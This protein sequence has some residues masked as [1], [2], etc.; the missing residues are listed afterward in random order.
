LLGPYAPWD[1]NPILSAMGLPDNRPDPV[2][3]TGH[4]DLVQTQ[5]GEWFAVFLGCQPYEQG[6][7][8]TGR[9]TFMHPVK[10]EDGWPVILPPRTPVPLTVKKPNLPAGETVA[11]P[12]TG[13]ISFTDNFDADKLAFRWVGLRAPVSQWYALS[14]ASKAL[15][16][17]PRAD[18]LS[19][20]G[21]PSFLAVRQQNNDFTCSVT[22]KAQAGTAKCV[23]GL[24]AYQNEGHFYALNAKIES[25]RITE[26][27]IEQPAGGERRGG[28]AQ[29]KVL[30]TQ[31]LE[32]LDSIKLQIEMAGSV[33]KCSYKAANGALTQLGENLQSSFLSTDTAGGFQ[34]VTVGMFARTE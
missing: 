17:E 26:I 14:K 22:L 1:K 25:G 31:K 27:S 29:G 4:A 3:C 23:A 6:F 28:G 20:T 34:G 11:T 7:Y 9:Q 16:L 18:K 33:M 13:N 21:N 10:W 8:N 24:A 12:T 19:G 5:N 15:L 2:T 32:N 30:A